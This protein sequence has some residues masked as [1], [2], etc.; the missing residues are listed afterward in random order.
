MLKWQGAPSHIPKKL[1]SFWEV[2]QLL[3]LET[4]NKKEIKDESLIYKYLF[5]NCHKVN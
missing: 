1:N 3:Q 5:L 2:Q 4:Q